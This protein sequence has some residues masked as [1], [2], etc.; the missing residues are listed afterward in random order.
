[1]MPVDRKGLEAEREEL[2][3]ELL[4]EQ[5]STMKARR[6]QRIVERARMAQ[7]FKANEQNEKMRRAVCRHHKG[8]KG[9]QGFLNGND[10]DYSVIKHT[11][12][13]GELVVMCT[14]CQNEWRK[15]PLELRKEDPKEYRRLM[16]EYQDAVN[17]PTDNEPSGTQI[18]LIQEQTQPA[19]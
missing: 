13:T 4:R 14:R 15:P 5:V 9:S 12:P 10:K 11:Y 1:M 7:V 6:E 2:E 18:F 3:L 19:A 16:Q 8:G 17:F